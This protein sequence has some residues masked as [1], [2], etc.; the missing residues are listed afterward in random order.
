MYSRLM[1]ETH[2]AVLLGP[3]A[4]ETPQQ[5]PTLNDMVEATIYKCSGE[6]KKNSSSVI[7]SKQPETQETQLQW[8]DLSLSYFLSHT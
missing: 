3:A 1:C 7:R 6:T 2:E 8:R 5:A 4:I